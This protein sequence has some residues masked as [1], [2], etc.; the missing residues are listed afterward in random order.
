MRDASRAAETTEEEVALEKLKDLAEKEA[1]RKAATGR[2]GKA[3]RILEE[4][5]RKFNTVHVAIPRRVNPQPHF[6]S[7]LFYYATPMQCEVPT[8]PSLSLFFSL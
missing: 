1:A 4:A 3:K 5:A 2:A 6:T 7:H 8:P